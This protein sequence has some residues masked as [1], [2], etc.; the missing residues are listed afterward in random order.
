MKDV[1]YRGQARRKGFNPVQVPDISSKF[2]NESE[3]IIRGMRDVHEAEIRNRTNYINSLKESNAQ[4]AEVRRSN[5]NLQT[6]FAEAYRDAELQHYKRRI[7]DVE[8]VGKIENDEWNK[9]K[10]LVPKAFKEYAKFDEIRGEKLKAAGTEIATRW[11]LSPQELKYIENANKEVHSNEVGLTRVQKRLEA[12][13]AD[14]EIINQIMNLSGRKLL[15]AQ[16]VALSNAGQYG[17]RQFL[18]ENVGLKI[19]G[20]NLSLADMDADEKGIYMKE[21]RSAF[22]Y[23]ETEFLGKFP[24]YDD[25]FIAEHLRPRMEKV[26]QEWFMNRLA[27]DLSSQARLSHEKEVVLV[28]DMLKSSDGRNKGDKFLQWI[29]ENSGGLSSEK[30]RSRRKLWRVLETLASDGYMEPSEFEEI[31]NHQFMMNGKLVSIRSQW[32]DEAESIRATFRDRIKQDQENKV[33][34]FSVFNSDVVAGIIDMENDLGR[35]VTESDISQIIIKREAQFPG[36]V[37][38]YGDPIKDYVHRSSTQQ[39]LDQARAYLNSKVTLT[40]ADLQ[41]VPY[42]VRKEFEGQIIDGDGKFTDDYTRNL[43]YIFATKLEEQNLDPDKQD[44]EI[45]QMADRTIK[46]LYNNVL[47][48]MRNG[49][50]ANA[51]DAWIDQF[52]LL[53]NEIESDKTGEYSLITGLFGKEARFKV[54]N[55]NQLKLTD[56]YIK[57]ATKSGTNFL[58]SKQFEEGDI[59]TLK[60]ATSGSSLPDFVLALA[61]VYPSKDPLQVAN[62]I[63]ESYGFEAIESQGTHLMSYLDKKYHTYVNHRPSQKKTFDAMTQQTIESNQDTEPFEPYLKFIKG[64]EVI[65]ADP[66]NEGYDAAISSQNNTMSTSR[67]L[68]GRTLEEYTVDEVLDQIYRGTFNEVGAFQ[69]EAD[70]LKFLVDKGSIPGE[71]KFDKETQDAIAL[72]RVWNESGYFLV[73]DGE[74]PSLRTLE[75]LGQSWAGIEEKEMSKLD[76]SENKEETIEALQNLKERLAKSGF[77][78]TLFRKEIDDVLLE[79][80]AAG[81]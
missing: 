77:N 26:K 79:N 48:G 18:S 29:E 4:E 44:P 13:G 58:K 73:S 1:S 20:L 55:S 80:L 59:E 62:I 50:Y 9:L 3:R 66:E 75:G 11:G 72:M 56:K 28:K 53:K 65:M 41:F 35:D 10:E 68:T 64:K 21:T 61:N 49:K 42:T 52:S 34:S 19:P 63:R 25:S 14:P 2:L 43:R 22:R 16:R 40:F 51:Q 6:E 39:S 67:E 23:L 69:I 46:T 7:K 74:T 8:E 37:N 33:Y 47:N 27:K 76:K 5:F 15:G 45:K 32:G 60:A 70:F 78:M 31:M 36:M 24:D 71:A 30:G 57:E 17:Y 38:N 81:I 54:L 12:S